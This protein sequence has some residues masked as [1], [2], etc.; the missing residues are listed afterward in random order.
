MTEE[1][2]HEVF[3]A[4]SITNTSRSVHWKVSPEVVEP[5]VVENSPE[6]IWSFA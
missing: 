4:Q 3:E 5:T 2:K 6:P 1:C